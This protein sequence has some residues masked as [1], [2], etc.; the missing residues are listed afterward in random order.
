MSS[1]RSSPIC[2]S[3][4]LGTFARG[5]RS[6]RG[7]GSTGRS[8]SDGIA[9]VA[10]TSNLSR[11]TQILIVRRRGRS[12]IAAMR[13]LPAPSILIVAL[14]FT[15]LARVAGAQN[16]LAPIRPPAVPLVAHDPYFSVW[17]FNDKLN[18]D[19]PRHW[20]GA[21]NAMT[22]IIR[23]DGKP[24]VLMGNPRLEGIEPLPQ[25]HVQVL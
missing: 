3:F 17:S 19:W 6:T 20:T 9:H 21:V 18:A 15:L 4:K 22:A 11:R 23:I 5:C 25:K 8:I 12:T 2:T 7:R 16:P 14:A 13:N 1:R 24:Y 10:R